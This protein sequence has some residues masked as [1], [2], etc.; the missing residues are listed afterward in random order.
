MDE[1]VRRFRV[2][3]DRHR[4]VRKRG[5]YPIEA[6][7]AAVEYAQSRQREGATI[8]R[9]ATELD[10]PMPTLQVWMQAA[11][12][13]FRRVAVAPAMSSESA[14]LVART[15]SG[16]SIE[17]LDLAGVVTLARALESR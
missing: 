16:L 14:R 10:L 3:A 11:A 12:P 17:G 13:V 4:G 2:A 7:R 9:A 6:R 8:H 15:P 1:R 5:R